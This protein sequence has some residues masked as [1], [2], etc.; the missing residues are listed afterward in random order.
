MDGDERQPQ[1]SRRDAG[2][3]DLTD[4]RDVACRLRHLR[5]RR[6][7]MGAVEPGPDEGLAGRRLALG[8]LVL[9]V[10]EDQVDA[11]GVQVERRP[12]VR[13]AHRRAFDVPAGTAGAERRLPG[14]LAGL[15]TLP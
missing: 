10:G 4:P 7:E 5:T 15:R 1:G 8:D 11:T 2:P 14:W 12:E 13:H 3:E 6:L 9:V